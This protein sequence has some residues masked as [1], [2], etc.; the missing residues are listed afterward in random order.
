[1]GSRK[2]LD[3]DHRALM[4]W[5]QCRSP[6]RDPGG[7]CPQLDLSLSEE[8]SCPESPGRMG[9]EGV[10]RQRQRLLGIDPK[11]LDFPGAVVAWGQGSYISL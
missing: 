11:S 8:E 4:G 9:R 6:K 3:K 5:Q 7:L 2:C 10:G 1:M